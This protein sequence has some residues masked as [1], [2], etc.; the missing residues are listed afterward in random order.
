MIEI[1]GRKMRLV[2]QQPSTRPAEPEAVP[3]TTPLI[4]FSAWAEDCRLYGSLELDGDRLSDMLNLYDELVL[5]DVLAQGLDGGPITE[6]AELSISR[7]EILLVEASG[8]RGN[9]SRRRHLRPVPISVRFRQP[10]RSPRNNHAG[11]EGPR[12]PGIFGT[13]GRQCFPPNSM[14]VTT[15]DRLP[16]PVGPETIRANCAALN[17]SLRTVEMPRSRG[18]VLYLK[19][20][21][22]ERL[23]PLPQVSAQAARC[24]ALAPVSQGKI[25]DDTWRDINAGHRPALAAW[26]ARRGDQLHEVASAIRC[27]GRPVRPGTGSTQ[28]DTGRQ[29]E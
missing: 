3:P 27:D 26:A 8:P 2:F 23:N 17:C 18:P 7:D 12:S 19:S 14:T 22:L 11:L 29:P 5:V 10:A 20:I 21:D 1:L 4:D 13:L 15:I 25:H 24:R 28:L 16:Q 9:P 6:I